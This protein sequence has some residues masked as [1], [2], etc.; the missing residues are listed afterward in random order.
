MMISNF[1]FF[2]NYFHEQLLRYT[3]DIGRLLGLEVGGLVE[4]K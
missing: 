3:V 2:S 1:A 4:G